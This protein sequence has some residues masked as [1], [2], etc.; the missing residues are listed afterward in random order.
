MVADIKNNTKQVIIVGGGHVG[1]S[2]ALLLAR[3][4]IHSTIIE[5]QTL[6]TCASPTY[7]DYRNT[8]LSRRTVS[9]Y[10][11]LGLWQSL[12]ND[13][14]AIHRVQIYEK[15]GFGRALLTKEQERVPDFG[16]VLQN[17]HLSHQL[18]QAVKQ[19]PFV[20]VIDGA[21]LTCLTQT[22]Q[23]VVLNLDS[24]DRLRACIVVG[25]DGQQSSVRT[26][27]GVGVDKHDYEQVAVVGI[28]K[29]SIPH[30][31]T[32]IEC[33]GRVGPLALLPLVS[34]GDNFWRS[35]VWICRQSEEGQYIHDDE[36]FT[37]VIQATFG[38]Q[39]GNVQSVGKRGAYPLVKVLAKQQV[40]G[41]CV[42]M[43]NAAHTLHPV[44]GQGFNLCMRDAHELAQRLGEAYRLG[45]DLG[46]HSQ[47][48]AYEQARL[49][50]Q[51]RVTL[52]CDVV[53]ATFGMN[54]SLMK[55]ARNIGLI[56]FD[57]LPMVKPLVAKFAMGLKKAPL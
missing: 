7:S 50:D 57:K 28:I 21:K 29:T 10:Q 12:A 47:L 54:H 43:G 13:A 18:I 53:I 42:L 39:I 56:L 23:E 46:E 5:Q 34:D 48:L 30:K 14:C 20:Q 35:V 6:P 31:H 9:I 2:F 41:R 32:A 26:L 36:Q 17:T 51:K 55:F 37:K 22:N 19:S 25:C 40:V 38:D 52:F 16:H 45:H 27:L 8:A 4:G 11:E 24:G 49:I 1:L 33:F 3:Q 15:G 44:A